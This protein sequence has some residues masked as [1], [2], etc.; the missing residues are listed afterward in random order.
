MIC[1]I[2]LCGILNTS[3]LYIDANHSKEINS[4]DSLITL[5]CYQ[6]AEQVE[7]TFVSNKTLPFQL[8][9]GYTINIH[10]KNYI[11]QPNITKTIFRTGDQLIVEVR[12]KN[13]ISIT[14]LKSSLSLCKYCTIDCLDVIFMQSLQETRFQ[15]WERQKEVSIQFHRPGLWIFIIV[16]LGAKIW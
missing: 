9:V 14:Q 12:E 15:Y 8:L 11:D 1:G 3:L 10:M 5:H 13:W 6:G 16:L 2:C 4:T 7:K